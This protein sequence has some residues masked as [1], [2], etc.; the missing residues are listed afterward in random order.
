MTRPVENKLRSV[1]ESAVFRANKK[2]EKEGYI[3]RPIFDFIPFYKCHHDPLHELIRIPNMLLKLAHQKLIKLDNS[4][5]RDLKKLP[6]QKKLLDWLASIG[7]KNAYKL[8]GESNRDSDPTV[9]LKSFTGSHCKLI[10]MHMKKQVLE[11]LGETGDKIV[12][13]FNYYF[14][15]HQ[16]YTHNYYKDKVI[17]RSSF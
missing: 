16:G 4:K 10:A 3:S 17:Q 5:S 11:D 9:L 2:K 1:E 8:K 13:L 12:W 15:L 14:R 7:L 6:A